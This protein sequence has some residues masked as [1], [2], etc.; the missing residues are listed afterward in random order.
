MLKN[1]VAIV[2]LG[3][4]GLPLYLLCNKKKIDVFGYD[5]D[6]KKIDKLKNNISYNS[7]IG[8]S[9]LKKIKKKNIFNMNELEGIS[10]RNIVIFCLPTP[11]KK[12]NNPDMSYIKNALSQ[13]SKYL[14]NETIMIIESTVYPGATREIFDEIIKKR[15]KPKKINYGFSS[16]RISPGQTDTKKFKIK[17][18]SIPKVVSANNKKTLKKIGVF[19]KYLFKKIFFAKSIE[20]AEM[21]KLLENSYR[22]VNIGL[23]N[24]FKMLCDK[25]KINIHD[26]ISAASTKPFGFTAFTPG[27]GVG[28]HC[29]PID[30][31]FVSWFAKKNNMSAD[32]IELARKKNLQITNW[33]HKKILNLLR[34]FKKKKKK[35]LLIGAAYKEDVN[36]Y[37]EAPTL[38]LIKKFN[39]NLNFI[40]DYYDPHI[41]I[42][43]FDKK[44]Y[45]SIKNLKYIS[46][47]DLVIL[48]TNHSILPYKKIL[49]ESKILVDTRGYYKK[50]TR[51]DLYHF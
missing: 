9:E 40:V 41:P 43:E 45:L 35:I 33:V 27:P 39:E 34:N 3:Y 47:Y 48:I 10:S 24:E 28:G 25:K 37:R 8:S 38:K 30:P 1:K 12:N 51:N 31:L 15:L 22:S 6:K 42:I 32:F 19:Y 11:V 23:V 29:I 18:H 4:V 16:E 26:V 2:G 21:S 5:L 50:I 20:I 46:K 36:D 13:I 14:G 17:Y 44:K 7:D 49:N